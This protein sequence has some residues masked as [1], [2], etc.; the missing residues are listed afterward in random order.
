[1]QNI[2]GSGSQ[3]ISWNTIGNIANA[4]LV[5]REKENLNDIEY[6]VYNAS[7][8]RVRKVCERK[9]SDGT[10]LTTDDKRYLGN[11]RCTTK[12]NADKRH[13]ITVGGVQKH[14]CIVQYS[15]NTAGAI[16]NDGILYRYQHANHLNSI[17]L[18]TNQA[19][20]VISYEEYSPFGETVYSLESL[21]NT[22]KEYRYSAQEK[23]DTTGLYYYG[24]RYYAPWLCRWT[25]PDPAG[26]ID[27]FNLYAF[28]GNEPIGKVDVM[29]LWDGESIDYFKEMLI[30]PN[31][32]FSPEVKKIYW[33]EIKKIENSWETYKDVERR[34]RKKFNELC[35][36]LNN[37]MIAH[38]IPTYKSDYP[39][40]EEQ[41][42]L[43]HSGG[44]IGS[45]SDYPIGKIVDFSKLSSARDPRID[46]ITKGN[47]KGYSVNHKFSGSHL[48]SLRENIINEFETPTGKFIVKN[49]KKLSFSEYVKD[50]IT[51]LNNVDNGNVLNVD[52][53]NVDSD[54][55]LLRKRKVFLEENS[56]A[57]TSKVEINKILQKENITDCDINHVTAFIT[58]FGQTSVANLRLGSSSLNSSI[59]NEFDGNKV[60]GKASPLSKEILSAISENRRVSGYKPQHP[61]YNNFRS[62][63]THGK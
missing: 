4:T 42:P 6:Y 17:G 32:S 20:Q 45:S 46:K 30:N 44:R 12:T 39:I 26:T 3:Q 34:E 50:L 1:M 60:G 27:G 37:Q 33:K 59:G 23:D 57:T 16:T 11:Y 56:Y 41:Y 55:E 36:N 58:H 14:D 38:K 25:R 29:G 49:G 31:Y 47:Q 63:D 54:A 35:V 61:D 8:I 9:N 2:N 10:I 53:G 28:V 19:G 7:G 62:S 48:Y 52:N 5:D 40:A 21:Y 18:E 51:R 22:T 43:F 15:T 13:S 24:Y